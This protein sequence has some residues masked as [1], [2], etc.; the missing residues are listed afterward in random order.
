MSTP[1]EQ[2][3]PLNSSTQTPAKP[4]WWQRF[5]LYWVSDHAWLRAMLPNFHKVNAE[6][7][8]SGHP[9][10]RTL[11][12]AR[13]L[14][15]TSV[16]SLRGEADSV[17]TLLERDACAELGLE[18]RFL[19]LRS[20]V[21][22][23]PSDLLELVAQLRDMPKPMLVHCKSGSDRTGLAA[24]LYRHV[25]EGEPLSRARQAFS[26]RYGHV[27]RGKAGVIHGMLDAYAAAHADTGIGF[28]DW[29]SQSYDP[30]A[31]VR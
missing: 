13:A 28:E 11:K 22:P 14:G 4:G 1:R 15:V 8:R 21:L 9:G 24:T 31:L 7:F 19:A 10:Y 18:L 5:R 26:W 3:E 16:L 23:S 25:I 20:T 6:L 27:S 12:R 29:V 2:R 17:A 30:D